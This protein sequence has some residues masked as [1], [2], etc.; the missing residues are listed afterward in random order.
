LMALLA[1][2][3]MP[4]S[5]EAARA[6]AGLLEEDAALDRWLAD[7]ATCAAA[8]HGLHFLKTVLARGQALAGRSK[9]LDVVRIVA[10]H[11]GRGGAAEGI[12]A[13]VAGLAGAP[14]PVAEV[15]LSGLAKGWPAGKT[16]RLDAETEKKVAL[17]LPKLPVASRGRLVRLA[18]RWGSEGMK[19]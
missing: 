18:E 2:A 7:A 14:A 19:K 15:V 13:L 9:A 16:V 5:E 3:E 4:P 10:E 8:A 1:L 12:P 17:L 6:V 11:H